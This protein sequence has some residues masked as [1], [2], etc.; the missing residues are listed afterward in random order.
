MIRAGIALPASVLESPAFIVFATFVGFNTIVYLGLTL[1][2]LV[3]LPQPVHPDQVRRLLG[4]TDE[5][6]PMTSDLV[7][8]EEDSAAQAASLDIARAFAALGAVT[9]LVGVVL[10]FAT[11]ADANDEIAAFAAGVASLV[12]SQVIARRRAR[13]VLASWLWAAMIVLLVALILANAAVLDGD[14]ILI[15]YAI[16]LMAAYGAVIVAPIAF[17]ASALVMVA[18]FVAAA[19]SPHIP[20]TITWLPV[21]AAAIATGAVLMRTRVRSMALL[22]EIDALS[23]RIGSTDPLTGLLTPAGLATL[24][25]QLLGTARRMDEP[26][27]LMRV[28]VDRMRE[29]NRAYGRRY[30]DDVLR[31]VAD[32]IRG[33]VREGDLV[34][35]WSGDEFLVLGL[36]MKPDVE[37][38]ATR[39]EQRV[40]A[41]SVALGKWPVSVSCG[42]ASGK[43]DR[44]LDALADEAGIELARHR[45]SRDRSSPSG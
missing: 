2:R 16:I 42:S 44:G 31:T 30:G 39:I 19:L 33:T 35:R 41:T 4:R 37:Q 24:A 29:A 36:G 28:N 7:R 8:V 38:L 21:A 18:L 43:A 12:V 32:A 23:R 20:I 10:V 1:S 13:P 3:P 25:P 14:P 5:E 6:T 9:L 27:C 17:V 26:I 34:T 40:E 11:T 45:A 22:P 15:G